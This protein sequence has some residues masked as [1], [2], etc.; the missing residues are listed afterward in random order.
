MPACS[1]KKGYRT[2]RHALKVMRICERERGDALRIYLCPH[3]GFWHFTSQVREP[4]Y[5][6]RVF[7]RRR[8]VSERF[9]GGDGNGGE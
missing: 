6:E 5:D 4:L 2:F 8:M 1:G 7:R 9:M 3:C